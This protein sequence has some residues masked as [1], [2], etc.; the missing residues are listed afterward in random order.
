MGLYTVYKHTAPNGKVYIGIT[1]RKPEHRWNGGRGYYMNKHFSAA[2]EKYGWD[3]MTHEILASGL[4][5]ESAC[6]MEKALI[7]AFNSNDPEFGYNNSSGGEFPNSGHK[8]TEEERARHSAAVKGRKMPAEFCEKVSRGKKGKS[9]GLNGRK[10]KDFAKSG[11]VYQID[12]ES[13]KVV[14]LFF[15][16]HEMNRETGFARTPVMEASQGK[17]RQAYGYKWRYLKRGE[18]NVSV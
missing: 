3:N 8:Q 4:E 2:I 7:R 16:F 14:H 12:M 17:R 9:N 11:L 5:K 18:G 15:G 13:E 6:E 10:G 1:S